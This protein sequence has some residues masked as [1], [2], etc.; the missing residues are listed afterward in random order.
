M[1][2]KKAKR[3]NA[4]TLKRKRKPPTK[5]T[6][7]A[8]LSKC[9]RRCALCYSFDDNDKADLQGQLAHISDD[10]SDSSEEN[11]AYLCLRHHDIYDS[12]RS[13]S[14]GITEGELKRA[15]SCLEQYIGL[16]GKHGAVQSSVEFKRG[17]G[18]FADSDCAKLIQQMKEI[19][20]VAGTIT[21][22]GFTGGGTSLQ[23]EMDSH[24]VGRLVRAFHR[25]DLDSLQV[26]SVKVS[27]IDRDRD[28]GYCP[29]VGI[30]RSLSFTEEIAVKLF[31]NAEYF[32]DVSLKNHHGTLRIAVRQNPYCHELVSLSCGYAGLSRVDLIEP[33]ILDRRKMTI[34]GLDQPFGLLRKFLFTFGLKLN[35]P[36][37]T[38]STL[39]VDSKFSSLSTLP[40]QLAA[41]AMIGRM[42]PFREQDSAGTSSIHFTG[43]FS[44]YFV[45]LFAVNAKEREYQVRTW[46][47]FRWV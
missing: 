44:V 26:A 15:K 20:E 27:L 11:L 42:L 35:S 13:Q 36:G 31:R 24:D 4:G 38:L 3:P 7:E 19:A 43:P 12:K 46:K 45:V 8:V 33:I 23:V 37:G 30:D 2:V 39:I 16:S 28:V 17:F 18:P 32:E 5:A 9:R 25:G 41:A 21:V 10:R 1:V 40:Q 34:D 29:G 47:E 22:R 6:E 14:K